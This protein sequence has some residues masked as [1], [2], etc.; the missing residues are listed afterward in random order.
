MTP[1][2]ALKLARQTG[3]DIFTGGAPPSKTWGLK[4]APT[5]KMYDY[6]GQP[7]KYN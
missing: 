1:A 7:G 4:L 2:L 5:G 6:P 3:S